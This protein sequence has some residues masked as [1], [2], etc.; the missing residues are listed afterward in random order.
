MRE[1]IKRL[2]FGI[3]VI[4]FAFFSFPTKSMAGNPV[5]TLTNP[6]DLG[7]GG[8][9]KKIWTRSYDAIEQNFYTSFKMEKKGYATISVTKPSDE[10]RGVVP[11]EIYL[12]DKKGNLLWDCLT[13]GQQNMPTKAYSYR[14]GL[15]AGS[16]TVR[17]YPPYYKYG[18]KITSTITIKTTSNA[19]WEVEDNNSFLNATPL[20]LNKTYTGVYG[21]NITSYA[22]DYY[23][24]KLTKGKHYSV[25]ISNYGELFSSTVMVEVLGPN[26][27]ELKDWT[28]WNL[29][30]YGSASFKPSKSGYYYI[31]IHNEWGY[32]T[33]GI[34]YG[35]HVKTKK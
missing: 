33:P 6:V 19:Y 1:Q 11:L 17:F 26:R 18:G 22:G 30:N 16:Y 14:V 27:K 32:N 28:A 34:K 23:K 5:G 7:N 2:L 13:D 31:K 15:K 20:K 10:E 35:I 29:R 25:R 8:R 9:C 3:F 4:I 12:Y 24:V 21:E